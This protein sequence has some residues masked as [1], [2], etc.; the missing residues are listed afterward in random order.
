MRII[1]AD[2][3]IDYLNKSLDDAVDSSATFEGVLLAAAIKEAFVM[4]LKN[5][6]ITPTIDAVEVVRCKDCEHMTEHYDTN[7]SVPYWTC[8]E[9]DSETDYDG[10]CHLNAKRI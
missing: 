2:A 6:K 10:F 8:D 9:W 3:F 4:D 1:D 5:E 7:G